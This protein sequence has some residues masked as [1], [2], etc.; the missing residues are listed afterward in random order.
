MKN[1]ILKIIHLVVMALASV[2]LIVFMVIHCKSEP[3]GM[4]KIMGGVYLLMIIWALI[5]VISLAKDLK[6]R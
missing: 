1:R 4:G 3:Q 5:R 2:V 6:N